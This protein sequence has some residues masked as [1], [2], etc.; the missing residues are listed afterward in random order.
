[1]AALRACDGTVSSEQR[2]SSGSSAAAARVQTAGAA[3]IA[4]A[5]PMNARRDIDETMFL[6]LFC[7]G[8]PTPERAAQARLNGYRRVRLVKR[9]SSHSKN[10][11]D[12]RTR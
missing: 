5:E 10:E 7:L 8:S 3:T 4:A 11:T 9:D 6:L 1:M 12:S 2:T